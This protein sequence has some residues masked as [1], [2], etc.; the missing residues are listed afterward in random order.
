MPAMWNK[1]IGY[2]YQRIYGTRL[3]ISSN[4]S[5]MPVKLNMQQRS[6][7][8]GQQGPARH[9][10]FMLMALV[11]ILAFSVLTNLALLHLHSSSSAEGRSLQHIREHDTEPSMPL[12]AALSQLVDACGLFVSILII[13]MFYSFA[14]TL[15]LACPGVG[16]TAL[17]LLDPAM[18]LARRVVRWLTLLSFVALAV[19]AAIGVPSALRY[20]YLYLAVLMLLSVGS[21]S[22]DPGAFRACVFWSRLASAA[23]RLCI[24]TGVQML[25]MRGKAEAG[26][27]PGDRS[28][29]RSRFAQ[30]ISDTA[31]QLGGIYLKAAYAARSWPSLH[32]AHFASEAALEATADDIRRLASAGSCQP[33]CGLSSSILALLKASDAF[34]PLRIH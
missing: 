22:Q 13:H 15:L 25:K 8:H 4:V 3:V 12:K 18:S 32:D 27:A 21:V 34:A 29:P 10:R 16:L 23:L 1:L 26:E 5:S 2:K 31:Q 24:D 30:S 33:A 11:V 7:A 28:S 17:V 14:H 19:G 20:G 9:Q 6:V